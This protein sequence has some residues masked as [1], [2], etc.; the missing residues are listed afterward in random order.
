MLNTKCQLLGKPE[1]YLK[2]NSPHPVCEMLV[3]GMRVGY[4]FDKKPLPTPNWLDPKFTKM[5]L[6]IEERI[7]VLEQSRPVAARI[8]QAMRDHQQHQ[9]EIESRINTGLPVDD[10]MVDRPL[11]DDILA[12]CTK[13]LASDFGFDNE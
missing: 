4:L 3:E 6:T 9:C 8:F 5:P 7:E 10:L 13:P 11:L 2:P 1:G 12:E